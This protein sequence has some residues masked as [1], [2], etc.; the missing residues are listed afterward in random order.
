MIAPGSAATLSP[1]DLGGAW[2]FAVLAGAGITIAGPV[3]SSSITGDIGSHTTATVT[4]EEN[5]MLTGTNHAGDGITQAAKTDLLLAY[6]DAV[7]RQADVVYSAGYNLSGTVLSGV[8]NS[9]SSLFIDGVLTL[10]G[11]GNS[12][13]VWIFQMGST[14]NVASSAQIILINGALASQ[15]FWQ[16]GSSATLETG[17]HLAGIILADQSITMKTGSVLNGGAFAS[18]GSVTLDAVT[19]SSVPEPSSALILAGSICVMLGFTRRR[20]A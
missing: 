9:P 10:D 11:Q 6:A 14:L 3:N 13:A 2:D 19:I 7:S 15:I 12:S 16:V 1:L 4:G 20:A 17:A 18:N 8:Y 5:L